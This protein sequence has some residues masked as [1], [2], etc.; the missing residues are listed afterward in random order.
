MAGNIWFNP[1]TQMSVLR[2]QNL[3]CER[4]GRLVFSNLNFELK[5]GE[6]MELRGPNGAGKSSLLRLLAGLNVPAAGSVVLGNGLKD[7]ALCEQAH[8]IGHGDALKFGLSVEQN[9]EFWAGFF[10]GA[11][12]SLPLDGFNLQHLK[13]DPVQF[14]SAGQK[15]RLALTRLLLSHRTLW[16][17]DE[18][19]VGLDASALVLLQK[20]IKN[21]TA[22][23]GMV[24]AATHVDLG[25]EKVKF[26]QLGQ[27]A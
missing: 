17:L 4:G 9:L 25:I 26:L 5:A 10:G 27:A 16:L 23:G 21:H 6:F 11:N 22:A 15:R 3:A 2:A 14:L 20:H 13:N 7:R 18:P 8:Y 24:M 19:S 1:V 12:A